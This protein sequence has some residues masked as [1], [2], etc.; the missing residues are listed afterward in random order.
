MD[1]GKK[2]ESHLTSASAFV[3]GGVQD[4]CDDACS[5]CLDDFSESN[6]S[7]TTNCRHDYHLQCI[8]EWC[9]RS[10]QCPMCWQAISLKDPA[11]QE[12]LDAVEH[13]RNIRNNPPRSS[14]IFHHPT[15]GEFEMQFPVGANEAELEERILQ[16]LASMGRHRQY[17]RRDSQR[18]RSGRPRLMVVSSVPGTSSSSSLSHMTRERE[19]EPNPIDFP[20]PAAPLLFSGGESSQRIPQVSSS[21]L[22]SN[23][24]LASVST[25]MS[26]SRR[27]ISFNNRSTTSPNQ[28]GAGPSDF[29]AFSDNLKNR[30]NS[31]SM[32]YRESISKSTRGWK[33]RFF[34]RSTS[35]S[36]FGSEV[37]REVTNSVSRLMEQ[38]EI[39]E[40][41]QTNRASQTQAPTTNP[42][43]FHHLHLSSAFHFWSQP[44]VVSGDTDIESNGRQYVAVSETPTLKHI[45]ADKKMKI[46]IVLHTRQAERR[47]TSISQETPTV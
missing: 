3:E 30:L 41:T 2:P 13:E 8:L 45:C 21:R 16:H 4:A 29:Q 35:V 1:E 38:L 14:T 39:G 47:K 22:D 27:G 37:R 19:T 40:N 34:S 42:K 44:K 10:S 7:S 43:S 18:T 6:P 26:A 12:L 23:S 17:G 5:I 33:E 9:Q 11:S 24:N 31:V 15:L 25:T 36:D 46:M 28:D 32:R 20:R